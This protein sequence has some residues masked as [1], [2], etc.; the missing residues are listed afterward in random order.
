MLATVLALVT[1]IGGPAAGTAAAAAPG[2]AASSEALTVYVSATDGD[3]DNSGGRSAPL[4]TIAAAR[5]ALAGRTSA[6]ARGT[7]YIRGG[8]YVLDD[9]IRL[10]GAENSW[11]TYAAYRNEKVTLTGS[12]ELPADGWKKLTELSHDTLAEPQYS[13]NTRLNTPELRDGVWV[14][15]LGAHGIDPG[16]LYKNGFNWVQQPFAPELVVDGGTQT[17]AEYPNGNTCSTTDT[18]CHLWGTGAKWKADGP[19]D[20]MNVD[21][22]ARFGPE[23]A[24]NNSGTTPRAQFEDKKQLVPDPEQRGTWTPEEMRRMT[25]SVFAVGGRA[26]TDDRYRRWAP[27]AVPT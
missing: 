24:W 1:S 16:T 6:E 22:D 2:P 20:L 13:S 8:T 7:V 4:K 3:D 5:D 17:L 14:Y 10:K 12:H 11:V 27:E 9:T 18:G 21:L 19:Q 25:P 26:A 15:D 23:S